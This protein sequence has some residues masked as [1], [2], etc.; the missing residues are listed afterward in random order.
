MTADPRLTISYILSHPPAPSQAIRDIIEKLRQRATE[1]GLRQVTD[2]VC[3]TTEQ[4][5]LDSRYASQPIRPYAVVFFAAAFSDSDPTE[6]GLCSLP[7][8]IEIGTATIPYGIEEWTWSASVRTRDVKT[9]SELFDFAAALGLW[10]S[11]TVAGIT[12]ACHR[13]AS[14]VVQYEQEW[15]ELPDEF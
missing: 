11:M 8:K 10:A 15:A 12:I 6:F 14:G 5:I 1:L 13:D 4:D 2:L 7:V 3:L 9:L